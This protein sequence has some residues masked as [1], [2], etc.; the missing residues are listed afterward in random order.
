MDE[1]TVLIVEDDEDILQLLSY[2]LVKDGYR[3]LCAESG[4]AALEMVAK[5]LP[6]LVLLDLMLPGIDGLA[7]CRTFKQ[8]EPATG[9][10]VIML[11]ARGEEADIVKGLNLGADD[12]VTKPFSPKVLLA[13]I[14]AVLRRK[15]QGNEVLLPPAGGEQAEVVSVNGLE[16]DSGRRL[17][18][19]QDRSIE[20]LTVTEF[21]ILCVLA[22]RPGRVFTRQQIIDQIRG[23]EYLVTERLV[24]VQIFGLRKKLAEAGAFVQTVRGIGYKFK[25]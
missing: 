14:K 7:V 19:F 3:V 25:E 9:I 17:V 8:K 6:D 10:P 4:E 22:K 23:Y 2:N 21:D 12:Y 5:S 13:R 24:D 11:T 1:A 15:G 18:T 16:I 20:N